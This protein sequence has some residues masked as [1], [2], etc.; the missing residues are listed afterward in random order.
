MKKTDE[1]QKHDSCLNKAAHD[2]PIFVLRAKD[3][4]ASRV[5]RFWADT[6][7]DLEIHVDKV[8]EAENLADEMDRWAS[9]AHVFAPGRGEDFDR[10]QWFDEACVV[11]D[12]FQELIADGKMCDDLDMHDFLTNFDACDLAAVH[13][14][15]QMAQRYRELTAPPQIPKKHYQ[16]II[17]GCS[18]GIIKAESTDDAIR[19]A[20]TVFQVHPDSTIEARSVPRIP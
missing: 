8:D 19:L 12:R 6:A 14:I 2:E 7:N 20:P 1:I 16:I 9:C 17:D 13:R 18:F 15:C 11:L 5:V 4:I 3:P 10:D